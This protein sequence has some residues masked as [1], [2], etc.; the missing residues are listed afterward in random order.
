MPKR[1]A[2]ILGILI[3]LSEAA[4]LYLSFNRQKAPV[5]LE[6]KQEEIN[7]DISVLILGQVAE[8]QGGQW[9][10]APGL[11]DTIVLLY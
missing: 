6:K 9:H 8:G 2:L 10:F 3:L 5:V 7:G 4:F 1:I 11:T